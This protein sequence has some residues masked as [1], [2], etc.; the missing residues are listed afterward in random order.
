LMRSSKAAR[1]AAPP[2]K[3]TVKAPAKLPKPV[4]LPRLPKKRLLPLDFE[5]QTL[6]SCRI[7]A[8]LGEQASIRFCSASVSTAKKIKFTMPD[9]EG[10][11]DNGDNSCPNQ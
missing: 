3:P 11:I 9:R 5:G 6:D 4:R 8:R 7:E 1:L 10:D 2:C